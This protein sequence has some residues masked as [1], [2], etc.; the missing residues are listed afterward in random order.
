LIMHPSRLNNE[1][2]ESN[3]NLLADENLEAKTQIYSCETIDELKNL[4]C[5]DRYHKLNLFALDKF[6][7]IEF[8]QHRSSLNANEIEAW[9]RLIIWLVSNSIMYPRSMA[10]LDS[11][12]CEFGFEALF[13]HLIHDNEIRN[14][15]M[16]KKKALFDAGL[17][18]CTCNK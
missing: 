11:R 10:F 1:Y 4:L 3:R 12:T 14:Y 2:C 13:I 9:L 17:N 15:F 8:R 18:G 7:T 6:G 5:D 16:T